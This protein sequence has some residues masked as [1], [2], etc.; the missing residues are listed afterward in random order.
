MNEQ[1]AL[2]QKEME[3]RRRASPS[4]ARRSGTALRDAVLPAQL[5]VGFFASSPPSFGAAPCPV[6]Q[7]RLVRSNSVLAN[8]IFPIFLPPYVPAVLNDGKPLTRKSSPLT[9]FPHG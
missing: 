3:L 5:S 2:I 8:I 6:A 9:L 4:L 1:A 7:L